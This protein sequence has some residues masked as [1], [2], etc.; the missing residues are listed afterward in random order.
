VSIHFD[1]YDLRCLPGRG[2]QRIR[3]LILRQVAGPKPSL[4]SFL[5]ALFR[6]PSLLIP[7]EKGAKRDVCVLGE[8]G[9]GETAAKEGWWVLDSALLRV[10]GCLTLH[11]SSTS[12]L[13]LPR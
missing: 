6:Q 12:T 1:P 7:A 2:I 8:G 5:L 3:G 13:Q 9:L 11:Y 4:S 10:G